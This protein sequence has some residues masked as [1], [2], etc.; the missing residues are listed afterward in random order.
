MHK[1]LLAIALAAAATP[2]IAH[3]SV[4]GAFDRRAPTSLKGVVTE[5]NWINPHIWFLV[6]ATGPG[7][8][9]ASWKIESHPVNFMRNAGVTREMLMAGGKPVELIVLPARR[10]GAEHVG[11]LVKMTMADGKFIQFTPDK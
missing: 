11:Y 8:Q 3:H 6:D 1:A 7:G 5:V 2:A 10:E 4:Y 9:R